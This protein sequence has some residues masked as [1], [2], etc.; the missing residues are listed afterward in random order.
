[1]QHFKSQFVDSQFAS[2]TLKIFFP[3]LPQLPSHLKI[4]PL[5]R[6]R[7]QQA[8]VLRERFMSIDAD[9]V[10]V[11]GLEERTWYMRLL[12]KFLLVL[13]MKLSARRIAIPAL[14]HKRPRP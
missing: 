4:T 8:P 3:R 11:V 10:S 14:A 7:D 2:Y 6:R 9:A 13:I 12:Y 1:L 5:W